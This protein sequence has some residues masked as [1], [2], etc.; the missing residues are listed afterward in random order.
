MKEMAINMQSMKKEI[1]EFG[2]NMDY[3][4]TE[5]AERKEIDEL[6]ARL[7]TELEPKVDLEEVQT[8]L[9]SC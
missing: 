2:I 4:K 8:A 5:K 6:K 7:R 9:N 3:V 1:Q